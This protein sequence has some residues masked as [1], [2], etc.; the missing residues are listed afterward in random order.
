MNLYKLIVKPAILLLRTVGNSFHF[1]TGFSGED[2]NYIRI[3]KHYEEEDNKPNL[4]EIY[5]YSEQLPVLDKIFPIDKYDSIFAEPCLGPSILTEVSPKCTNVSQAVCTLISTTVYPMTHCIINAVNQYIRGPISE[6]QEP[7]IPEWLFKEVNSLNSNSV[8]KHEL[9]VDTISAPDSFKIRS[10]REITLDAEA[11]NSLKKLIDNAV[12]IVNFGLRVPLEKAQEVTNCLENHYARGKI[13]VYNQAG[14]KVFVSKE[15]KGH[16]KIAECIISAGDIYIQQAVFKHQTGPL[17]TLLSKA[18]TPLYIKINSV[19]ENIEANNIIGICLKGLT[20]NE[21][22]FNNLGD[23][24]YSTA[25]KK[26]INVAHKC[27]VPHKMSVTSLY[28]GAEVSEEYRSKLHAK[29]QHLVAHDIEEA[30]NSILSPRALNISAQI[31]KMMHNDSEEINEERMTTFRQTLLN[32]MLDTAKEEQ[33]H[34]GKDN[35]EWKAS[36]DLMKSFI[37]IALGIISLI[38]ICWLGIKKGP[39]VYNKIVKSLQKNEEAVEN[40]NENNLQEVSQPNIQPSLEE[41]DNVL[42]VLENIN[43]VQP[44]ECRPE[45]EGKGEREP[46]IPASKIMANIVRKEAEIF[47]AVGG[48][49]SLVFLDDTGELAVVGTSNHYSELI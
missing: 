45:G 48:Q 4:I 3:T 14:I 28:M 40:S 38:G 13:I 30:N 2:N 31:M 37:E 6:L 19:E 39:I 32:S 1:T 11:R 22:T 41:R 17:N 7:D 43:P 34:N 42:I 36:L 16:L 21:M 26:G 18:F 46:L 24:G 23:Q 5:D 25:S 49:N 10:S 29:I 44:V 27:I 12:S 35:G 9:L 20:D 33:D 8:E 15:F 47:P